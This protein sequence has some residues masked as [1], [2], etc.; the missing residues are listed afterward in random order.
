V[1]DFYFDVEIAHGVEAGPKDLR[2]AYERN[3]GS[4]QR[5]HA[6]ELLVATLADSAAA[7]QLAG[8]AGHAPSLREAVEMV[9]PGTP[10]SAERARFPGAPGRWKPYESVLAETA[11]RAC[12]GPIPVAGGW[13]VAQVVS[14]EQDA[15]ALEQLPP[16]AAQSIRQ[17]AGDIARERAFNRKVESL[18]QTLKPE[19]RRDR[20]R[21]IPWP[22]ASA[23]SP[24][25]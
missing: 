17:Q 6:V 24:R 12:I 23:A 3:L 18:R 21:A 7:T 11:P 20:L 14:K 22:V 2:E 8:H 13:L 5:L 1:L 4:L 10:V 16:E 25:S 19:V 15:L 9:A